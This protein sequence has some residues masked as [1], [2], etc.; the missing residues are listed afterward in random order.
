MLD[1]IQ[2]DERAG[3]EHKQQTLSQAEIRQR[4]E[5]R[6]EAERNGKQKK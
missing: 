5:R 2:R 1:E 6:R 4:I 3:Q